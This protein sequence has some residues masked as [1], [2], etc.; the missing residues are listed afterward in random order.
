MVTRSQTAVVSL[1][2]R[3]ARGTNC[4]DSEAGPDGG[5]G[6]SPEVCHRFWDKH[7]IPNKTDGDGGEMVVS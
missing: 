6:R 7:A 1:A 2:G 3:C 4:F 5:V